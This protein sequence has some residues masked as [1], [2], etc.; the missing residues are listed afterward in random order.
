MKANPPIGKN[1]QR[2]ERFCARVCEIYSPEGG[3]KYGTL[4]LNVWKMPARK[5]PRIDPA[6]SVNL[7]TR[8]KGQTQ[9]GRIR[10]CDCLHIW[11]WFELDKH[12]NKTERIHLQVIK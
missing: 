7:P 9:I 12:G 1:H 6:T 10:V 11:T 4:C 3:D 8:A 5:N 2:V